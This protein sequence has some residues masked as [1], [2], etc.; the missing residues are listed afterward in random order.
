MAVETNSSRYGNSSSAHHL[1]TIY[2]F[3]S[4]YYCKQIWSHS[5]RNIFTIEEIYLDDRILSLDIDPS[6]SVL[7]TGSAGHNR[8]P[9]SHLFDLTTYVFFKIRISIKLEINSFFAH[10]SGSL[11]CPLRRHFLDGEGVYDV[12]FESPNELLTGDFNS[13]LRLWDLRWVDRF[14]TFLLYLTNAQWKY[15][16][17]E[18][19]HHLGWSSWF[20]CQLHCKRQ[21]YDHP[22]GNCS[23]WRNSCVGQETSAL[24]SALFC[25]TE[26]AFTRIQ[27]RL[28]LVRN[29]RSPRHFCLG[30]W[31]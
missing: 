21:Q 23:T 17:A 10:S 9:P 12:H 11:I 14:I 6:G 22:Y 15:Q 25:P 16:N 31:F 5:W 28:W 2:W 7:C 13:A 18:K 24:C 1:L 19:C 29:V 3:L 8:V 4:K 30:F 20:S 26:F 27:L